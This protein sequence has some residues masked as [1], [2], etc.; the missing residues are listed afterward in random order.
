M[1]A[2]AYQIY[3]FFYIV[4]AFGVPTTLSKMLGERIA[5]KE[6]ANARQVFKVALVFVSSVGLICALILWFGNSYIATKDF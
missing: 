1:Y 2:M 3:N 4:S 6:Y 5:L